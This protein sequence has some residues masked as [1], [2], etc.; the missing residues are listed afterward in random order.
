MKFLPK[1][2]FCLPVFLLV[3]FLCSP[4]ALAEKARFFSSKGVSVL[5]SRTEEVKINSGRGLLNTAKSASGV[6]SALYPLP[7]V[8]ADRESSRKLLEMFDR[9]KNWMF[10]GLENF[11]DEQEDLSGEGDS[12]NDDQR[13]FLDS[14]KKSNGVVQGFIRGEE[15]K[16]RTNKKGKQSQKKD[17]SYLDH[18]D[19]DEDRLS[20]NQIKLDLEFDKKDE[21]SSS[22]FRGNS[23]FASRNAITDFSPFAR[24][25]NISENPFKIKQARDESGASRFVGRKESVIPVTQLGEGRK[26][27]F[28]NS[29]GNPSRS[30]FGGNSFFSGKD[31][32]SGEKKPFVLAPLNFGSGFNP[33]KSTPIT[34][35]GVDELKKTVMPNAEGV[36][37]L[38]VGN[39]IS[40]IISRPPSI[41]VKR[42]TPLLFQGN[43]QQA[44]PGVRGGLLNS[45]TRSPFDKKPGGR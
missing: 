9:K 6:P 26:A 40:G 12:I 33:V 37:A 14:Y 11:K 2:T 16:S 35:V 8:K 41:S 39:P 25:K 21:K 4:I 17:S 22:A 38:S 5:K 43:I 42:S 13:L 23:P 19:E 24:R 1:N 44:S 36:K 7:S 27:G 15:K 18:E 45:S 28:F 10:H 32:S 30:V 20:K 31:Q 34:G 3:V 29:S